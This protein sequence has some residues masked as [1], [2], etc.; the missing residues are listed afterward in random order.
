MDV[1]LTVDTISGF[2]NIDARSVGIGP[3]HGPGF[4]LVGKHDLLGNDTGT[5]SDSPGLTDMLRGQRTFGI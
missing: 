3:V 2:Q 5:A 4:H 1:A